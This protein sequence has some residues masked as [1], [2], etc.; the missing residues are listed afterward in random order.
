MKNILSCAAATLLMVGV[1]GVANAAISAEEAKQLGGDK[2]TLFGAE[3]A[4]NADG[5]IPAYS[6]GMTAPPKGYDANSGKV[7]DPFADEKPLF[8]ID[9]KNL[10]QYRSNLAAGILALFQQYPD[11]RMNVYPSHRTAAYPKWVL[12]NTVKNATTAELTGQV[13]GDG[14]K[15][16]YA[17]L[18]FPIP[19][20]GYEALWN[21]FFRWQPTFWE[22]RN[23][24]WLVTEG[25][26]TLLGNFSNY[27]GLP[28]YDQ[29]KTSLQDVYF[30]KQ[31]D[32]GNAPSSQVGYNLIL[33]F[34]SDYSKSNQ[35]N[36]VYT[37]GQ[38][39]TRVAPEFTYDTP[40]AN[41]GGALTYDEVFLYS[42]RPDRFDFKLVGKKELYVPYNV[43]KPN[44]PGVTADLINTP[45]YPNPDYMRWEKHRVWVVEATL[46]PGKRH[47]IQKKVFYFDE[48]SWN[49]LETDGYDSSGKLYRLGLGLP[50]PV[51]DAK[52]PFLCGY[53]YVLMDLTRNVYFNAWVGPQGDIRIYDKP[54]DPGLFTPERLSA[55]GVR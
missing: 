43:S 17:G 29:T 25:H 46:K 14:V 27:L 9:A 32:I 50:V 48:D 16:S 7:P 41:F 47:V 51:Y 34:S 55:T 31:L 23:D 53:S 39:R 21:Y 13:V 19:K 20:D 11:F 42:G 52:Q 18:P 44:Q 4:A 10:D 6:G 38:R 24:S 37:P 8:S 36:W 2:L 54:L 33:S 35:L 1:A 22:F 30:F 12:D 40:A 3:K 45:R 15:N 28:Y 5:S 49:I 26:K